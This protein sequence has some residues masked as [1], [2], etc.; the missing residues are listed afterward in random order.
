MPDVDC[1]TPAVTAS[2]EPLNVS[3]EE[4][5][6][7]P[8]VAAK[9]TWLL[10]SD[11]TAKFVVVALVPVALAKTKLPVSVVEAEVSP[12][13]NTISVEVALEG[14]GYENDA[15]PPAP[16]AEP[17]EETVPDELI[18]KHSVVLLAKPEMIKFVEDAVVN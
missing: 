10:V 14:N 1:I 13:L 2:V 17:V 5:T 6:S 18:C 12:P 8:P 4:P 16:H 9:G 11:E 15:P 3:A 7:A